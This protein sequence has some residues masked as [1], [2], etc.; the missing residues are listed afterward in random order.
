MDGETISS[1]LLFF[2]LS[3]GELDDSELVETDNE[4]LGKVTDRL[5]ATFRFS[6]IDSQHCF[7][8]GSSPNNRLLIRL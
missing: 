1:Q 6:D 5:I 4:L 8:T 7:D 3:P 2:A